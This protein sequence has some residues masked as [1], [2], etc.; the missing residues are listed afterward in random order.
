MLKSWKER[1]KRR[2]LEEESFI[3]IVGNVSTYTRVKNEISV[4][5]MIFTDRDDRNN[6]AVLGCRNNYDQEEQER[7]F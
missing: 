7:T 1:M 5:M 6:I 4:T 3:F 2:L